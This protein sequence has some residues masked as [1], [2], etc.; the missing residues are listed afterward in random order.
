MANLQVLKRK[1]TFFYDVFSEKHEKS[2][3]LM[4]FKLAESRSYDYI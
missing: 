2:S 3:S 4:N 1:K